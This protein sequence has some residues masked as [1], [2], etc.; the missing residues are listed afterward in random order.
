VHKQER[1]F[2]PTELGFLVTDLLTENFAD[3][4]EVE[5]TARMEELLDEI[6]EGRANYLSTVDEFY[7]KFRKDLDEAQANMTNVKAQE[8]PTEEVCDKCGSMM[9]IKWGRFGHFLACSAY[10]ECRNTREVQNYG[11]NGSADPDSFEGETCEKCNKPMVLKKGRY[12]QFLACS[13]YPDCRNTRRILRSKDGSIASKADVPLDEKCPRCENHLVLKHGRFGEFT[14]CSNYPDCKYIKQKE[15]GVGCPKGG[16]GGQIVERRSRRGKLFY[17]CG[18]YPDC[19]F[20]VWY[21][22]VPEPCPECGS[23]LLIEKSS[24]RD[25]PYLACYKEECKF[26]RTA[27]E[28]PS[29]G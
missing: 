20:T 11:V 1:K 8:I 6:E 23:P 21:K 27:A 3:I 29:A 18:K 22:P 17:G 10:P 16:C 4:M 26:K 5:Y 28:A 12:G 2:V 9:V 14:A 25:G 13:G 24:K 19:D 15:V 7:K